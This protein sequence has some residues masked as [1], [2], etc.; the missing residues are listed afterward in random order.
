MHEFKKQVFPKLTKPVNPLL[1]G[2]FIQY[3]KCI[4]NYIDRNLY[5]II[6]NDNYEDLISNVMDSFD[7]SYNPLHRNNTSYQNN[8]QYVPNNINMRFV[9]RQL[10][11]FNLIIRGYN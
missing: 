3:I 4:V 6:M 8:N 2:S 5:I 1:V 10:D 7:M 11:T 9:N